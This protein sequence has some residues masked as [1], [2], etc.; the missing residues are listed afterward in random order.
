M[1]RAPATTSTI[2][3]L[4]SGYELPETASAGLRERYLRLAALRAYRTLAA[5][6]KIEAEYEL[7]IPPESPWLSIVER[8]IN[9]SI[10]PVEYED[11]A[12]ADTVNEKVGQAALSFF[13]GAADVLPSEPFLYASLQGNLV[14]EFSSSKGTMTA[15]ISPE[16]TVVFTAVVGDKKGPVAIRIRKGTN[17]LREDV[18]EVT[19]LLV[20]SHGQMD[21]NR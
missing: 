1:P 3:P 15:V 12:S 8:R 5:R 16:E 2:D 11:K 4:A 18:R 7:N 6:V 17:R 19:R 21:P 14:A 13:R 20:Q 9:G 10:T